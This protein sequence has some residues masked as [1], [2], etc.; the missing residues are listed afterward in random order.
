[1]AHDII[2]AEDAALL[3]AELRRTRA[4]ITVAQDRLRRTIDGTAVVNSIGH[5]INTL[6]TGEEDRLIG[7]EMVRVPLTSDSIMSLRAAADSSQRLLDK[8]LPSLK[9][10][11]VSGEVSNPLAQQLGTMIKVVTAIPRDP[12]DS[13]VPDFR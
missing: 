13:A 2:N 10:V 8:L 12:K 11:D 6:L 9:A 4:S 7:E 1:M 5:A 3:R